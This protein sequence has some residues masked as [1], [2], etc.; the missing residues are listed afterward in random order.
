MAAALAAE[1][2]Y[3]A[4]AQGVAAQAAAGK[5]HDTLDR[6][7]QIAAPTLVLVGAEDIVT[8]LPYAQALAEG[9]PGATLQVLERGGHAAL[10]EFEDAGNA[11]LLAFLPS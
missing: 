3:P 1:D 10:W 8:P 4:S 2:P 5:A 6:L 11:A 7:G 9:I